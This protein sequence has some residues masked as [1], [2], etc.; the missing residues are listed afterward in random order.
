MLLEDF[1]HCLAYFSGA[2]GAL[3]FR[4]RGYRVAGLRL[5]SRMRGLGFWFLR[6]EGM[7]C[8]HRL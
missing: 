2:G 3:G 5:G 1:G 8:K 4:V 7:D 6:N